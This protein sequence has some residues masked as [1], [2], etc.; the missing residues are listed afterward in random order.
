MKE[1]LANMEKR[2]PENEEVNVTKEEDQD[3]E[4]A[5]VFGD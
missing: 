3:T 2:K 5:D 4:V 1:I